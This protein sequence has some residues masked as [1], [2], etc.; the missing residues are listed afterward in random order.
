MKKQAK[1]HSD[2]TDAQYRVWETILKEAQMPLGWQDGRKFIS[3]FDGSLKVAGGAKILPKTMLAI[4]KAGLIKFDPYPHH[5]YFRLTEFGRDELTPAGRAELAASAG[6]APVPELRGTPPLNMEMMHINGDL[7]GALKL[8]NEELQAKLARAEAALR[9]MVDYVDEKAQILDLPLGLRLRAKAAKAWLN[10]Q[11]APKMTRHY[12]TV[13]PSIGD[14]VRIRA[15]AEQDAEWLE[16]ARQVRLVGTIVA[17]EEPD[18]VLV[19]FA[20]GDDGTWR[21]TCDELEIVE[22]GREISAGE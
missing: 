11:P 5:T 15:A 3:R 22:L 10:E 9:D 8:A 17:L 6:D 2:L 21:L 18:E 7:F 12:V 1:Y 4:E 20:P 19:R 16:N 14:K 13:M